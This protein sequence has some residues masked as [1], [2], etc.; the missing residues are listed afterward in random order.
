MVVCTQTSVVTP[1]NTRC[2]T[3]SR[4]K[5]AC[6]SVPWKAPL[7]GLSIT[8]SPGSGASS[9]TISQPGSPRTSN[10][11]MGPGSPMRRLGWPRSRLAIGQSDRSGR[12]DSRVCTTGQPFSR[13]ALSSACVGATAARSSDTSLPS[14]SPKPPGSMKS[15]CMSMTMSAARPGGSAKAKGRAGMVRGAVMGVL[16]G[17]LTGAFMGLPRCGF[18]AGCARLRWCRCRLQCPRRRPP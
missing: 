15:R 4:S 18:A 9:G 1:A 11:P 8:I 16:T 17:L 2:V 3:P 7:P 5:V 6:R 14:D 10:R 12:W 13:Q